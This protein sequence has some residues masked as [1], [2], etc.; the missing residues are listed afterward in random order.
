MGALLRLRFASKLWQFKQAVARVMK[1]A[2]VSRETK[3][4]GCK[5]VCK[6]KTS[7]QIKHKIAN[8]TSKKIKSTQPMK[9]FIYMFSHHRAVF[10]AS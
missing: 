5:L 1:S 9:T 2:V 7:Y 6:G 3:L 8:K 4:N 10:Q